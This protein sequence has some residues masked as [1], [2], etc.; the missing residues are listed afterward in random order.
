MSSVTHSTS[1]VPVSTIPCDGMFSVL[2]D[3]LPAAGSLWFGLLPPSILRDAD[4]WCLALA[5]RLSALENSAVNQR[6]GSVGASVEW[7]GW[8]V[9]WVAVWVR[10][11]RHREGGTFGVV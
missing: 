6:S 8:E 2:R 5:L 7:R 9:G 11:S 4:P 1:V 10:A 3:A